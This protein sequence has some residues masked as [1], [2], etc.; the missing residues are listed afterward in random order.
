MSEIK[1]DSKY[2]VPTMNGERQFYLA[3][4]RGRL[5]AITNAVRHEGVEWN[6][7]VSDGWTIE[8]FWGSEYE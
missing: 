6:I 7:L 3:S 8:E 5:E 2:F 4:K 1:T